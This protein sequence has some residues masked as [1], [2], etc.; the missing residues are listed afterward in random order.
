MKTALGFFDQIGCVQHFLPFPLF[1]TASQVSL[2]HGLK[3]H[4]TLGNILDVKLGNG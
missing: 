4:G 2:R 3:S 1:V